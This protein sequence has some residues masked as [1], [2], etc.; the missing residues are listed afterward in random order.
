MNDKC[1]ICGLTFKEAMDKKP[2]DIHSFSCSDA[3]L[4]IDIVAEAAKLLGM[5]D[6][7]LKELLDA[8]R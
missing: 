2:Y 8:A 4:G 7:D 5:S 6:K 1:T 3:D